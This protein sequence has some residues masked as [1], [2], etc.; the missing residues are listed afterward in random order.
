MS[1]ITADAPARDEVAARVLAD[2]PG[3][4]KRATSTT[5]PS[6]SR[7]KATP[8]TKP[9]KARR[10]KPKA[11]PKPKPAAKAKPRSTKA[12]RYPAW[13]PDAV[14]RSRVTSGRK[15]NAKTGEPFG[16][17]TV[18]YPGPKQHLHIRAV[19]AAKID[20]E[21]TPE[22]ILALTGIKSLKAL[23][24]IADWSA[25]KATMAPMRPLSREMDDG[26]GWST[27]RYGAAALVAWIDQLK[28]SA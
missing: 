20:G 16:D 7:A 28:A 6:R 23:R 27:G 22:K 14:K 3:P 17:M 4:S 21:P 10:P 26:T 25:D 24:A 18:S 19:V 2:M 9:A 8:A 11:A 13:L 12:D 15:V 1:T 5:K